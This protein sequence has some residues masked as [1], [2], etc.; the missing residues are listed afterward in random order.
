MRPLLS[1]VLLAACLIATAEEPKKPVVTGD[2]ARIE[3][4]RKAKM[5]KIDKPISFDTP[6]ADAILSALEVFPEDNPWNLV[7]TDWSLHPKSKEIV[8][9]IGNE[10]PLR[11]NPDMGF[12]LIPPDQKKIDVKLVS[13]PDESDKGPYPVPDIVPIEG[14]PAHYKRDAKLKNLTLEDVQRDKLNENGDRHG[15]VVDPTNRVLYEFYQLKK[16]DAGWQAACAAKFDL[17]SNKLR[18]DGWTSSDA[19]GLP[20]FPAVIRFDEL[21]R[22][23][24]DHAMRVTVRRTRRAYVHPAT[25][26]ASKLTDENLPRMGE[27]IRLKKDFDTSK[28]SAEVKTIL[29]GLKKYGMLVAD[30]GIEW[31]LSCAPD[32][33]IPNLH[34]ELRKVK[35]SDFEVIVPP[36]GYKPER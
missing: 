29:E 12:V 28:F 30:N 19:A 18:P 35:G 31:A 22:G 2:P 5:P 17:K 34:A 33:R 15:I 14:W 3:R 6:E 32:E 36:A 26:F 8:A 7:V 23:S 9:S 25:H 20:I 11:Y 27:R 24:I 10:K 1:V 4:I 21:K 13:Y 16:T